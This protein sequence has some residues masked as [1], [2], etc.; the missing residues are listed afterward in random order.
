MSIDVMRLECFQKFLSYKSEDYF[1]SL[2]E[3][4]AFNRDEDVNLDEL[5]LDTSEFPTETC[6][7]RLGKYISWPKKKV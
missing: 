5:L 4:I 6:V 7:I 2:A 1:L 3:Q